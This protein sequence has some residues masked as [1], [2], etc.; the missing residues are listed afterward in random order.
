[1]QR[2]KT[3]S[4]KDIS[5]EEFLNLNIENHRLRTY[6]LAQTP[7]EAY[8]LSDR[9][10]GQTDIS[11]LHYFLTP[12]KP[13]SP[14]TIACMIDKKGQKRMIKLD[15][16]HR[17]IAANILRKKLRVVFIDLCRK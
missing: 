14:I 1:M 16:V 6:L 5:V 15:G 8:P 3:S 17:M 10:R 9:P 4:Y 13:I 11:S 12:I 7:E 2:I